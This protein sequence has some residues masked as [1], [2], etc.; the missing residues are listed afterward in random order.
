VAVPPLSPSPASHAAA[1]FELIDNALA[2]ERSEKRLVLLLQ[3][4][5]AELRAIDDSL[6]PKDALHA[7]ITDALRSLGARHKERHLGYVFGLAVA[8]YADWMGLAL[9]LRKKLETLDS[10]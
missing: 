6:E 7:S 2:N 5:V 4:A 1:L 10:K 9:S 8:H 3:L